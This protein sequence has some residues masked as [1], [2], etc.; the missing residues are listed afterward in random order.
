MDEGCEPAGRRHSPF[1]RLYCFSLSSLCLSDSLAVSCVPFS[2]RLT[3]TL[4]SLVSLVT[5][6]FVR[7]RG[8][9][10]DFALLIHPRPP[11]LAADRPEL[12]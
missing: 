6:C 2:F 3:S 12:K 4:C 7:S 9:I 10:L 1:H 5:R 11:I 8:M